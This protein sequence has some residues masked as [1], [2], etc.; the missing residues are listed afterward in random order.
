M[1]V[2]SY[3]PLVG[4]CGGTGGSD[5]A[6]AA[7]KSNFHKRIKRGKL[8]SSPAHTHTLSYVIPSLLFSVFEKSNLYDRN[9]YFGFLLSLAFI[10][11]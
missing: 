9:R 6:A 8:H 5:A 11:F 1:C 2:F 7:L 10:S 4:W 3:V